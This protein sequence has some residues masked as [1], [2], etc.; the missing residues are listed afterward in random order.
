MCMSNFH[1]VFGQITVSHTCIYFMLLYQVKV[2]EPSVPDLVTNDL[3]R[4]LSPRRRAWRKKS[5]SDD[6]VTA[7]G[8]STT[9]AKARSL[10]PR[11]SR[12]TRERLW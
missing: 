5:S 4:K 9:C 7:G 1:T 3:R 8:D 10:R 11:I 12:A 6:D 2:I